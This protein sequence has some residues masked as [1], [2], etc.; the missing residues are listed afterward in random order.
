MAD[1]FFIATAAAA[2]SVSASYRGAIDEQNLYV[3]ENTAVGIPGSA[4]PGFNR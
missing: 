1:A 3:S 4:R 2:R